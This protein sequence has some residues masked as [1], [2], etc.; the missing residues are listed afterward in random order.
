[1]AVPEIDFPFAPHRL[2]GV[3][4]GCLLNHRPALAAL[5]ETVNAVPYQAAPQAPVLYLKPRNT[6]TGDGAT[7]HVPT[8]TPALELG[9]SLGLVI[10]RTACRVSEAQALDLVAG[11][12]IVADVCI[13]HDRFYRPSV[14]LRARDGHCPIGPVVRPLA[15]PD[16]LAVRV[17]VDGQLVHETTTG[18][19]IR[20][21]ARLLADVSEFMTLSPGDVLMLGVSHGAP[22]LRPGQAAAVEI[23]GL[24]RLN[25]HFAAEE[26]CA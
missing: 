8:G 14:R 9:A 11:G 3:V 5:G 22:L 26:A 18:D 10:G 17:W 4:Y 20:H 1:M 19:R 6:L 12:C 23:E 13:P 16:A 15:D 7:V 24:G 25:L 21:A 2:S